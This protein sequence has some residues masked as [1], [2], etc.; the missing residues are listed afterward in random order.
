MKKMALIAMKK[1]AKRCV[2]G[3]DKIS[4]SPQDEWHHLD[5]TSLWK[6]AL[7][8]DE[9]VHGIRFQLKWRGNLA[10]VYN[11]AHPISILVSNCQRYGGKLGYGFHKVEVKAL[12]KILEQKLRIIYEG[13]SEYV[14]LM[15]DDLQ[16]HL[17]SGIDDLIGI[18]KNILSF[19]ATK[20][21][22]GSGST[23]STDVDA[24]DR[25]YEQEERSSERTPLELYSGCS[26][27]STG[28]CLGANNA[29]VKLDTRQIWFSH[30]YADASVGFYEQ[31]ER[32]SKRTLLDLYSGCG[33]M[34]TGLCHGLTVLV[35]SLIMFCCAVI[36]FLQYKLKG[37]ISREST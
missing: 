35:L 13:F 37:E 29:G 27:I 28:H 14:N 6:C 10:I 3:L 33:A 30:F 25:F 9:Y 31:E 7:P 1:K 11:R 5:G 15:Q 4:E 24:S 23:I 12:E 22:G 34:S 16:N 32:S 18:L 36:S 21:S 2:G 17:C 20:N 26:A 8:N 19:D